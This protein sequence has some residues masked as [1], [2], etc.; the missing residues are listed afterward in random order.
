MSVLIIN[1]PIPVWTWQH[2]ARTCP[3]KR[4]S[5]GTKQQCQ[6]RTTTTTAATTAAPTTATSTATT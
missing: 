3:I 2:L 6:I 1:A 5:K 4:S